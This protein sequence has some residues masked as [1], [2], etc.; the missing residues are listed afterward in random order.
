MKLKPELLR[1]HLMIIWFLN[2][3]SAYRD[4]MAEDLYG[5][6]VLEN[7]TPESCW[8]MGCCGP[9]GILDKNLL[10]KNTYPMLKIDSRLKPKQFDSCNCGVFWCLFIMDIM[11]QALTTYDE[12]LK[13][14]KKK[15]V[16]DSDD[17]LDSTKKDLLPSYIGI[18]RTWVHPNQL[19]PIIQNKG[20]AGT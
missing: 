8:L 2:L 3:A 14:R 15:D 9:F 7:Q 1:I 20:D 5:K 10:G 17:G 4:M 12:S 19:I 18:G 16:A 13:I 6:F 11:Q